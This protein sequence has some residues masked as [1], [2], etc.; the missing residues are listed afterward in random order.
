VC[1][2]EGQ[3]YCTDASGNRVCNPGLR[4]NNATNTCVR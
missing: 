2:G 4:L 1:G 3:T